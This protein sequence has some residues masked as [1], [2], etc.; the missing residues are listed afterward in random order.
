MSANHATRTQK[1]IQAEISDQDMRDTQGTRLLTSDDFNKIE[2]EAVA[3]K[4]K[5]EHAEKDLQGT[6][7][8]L[9][10]ALDKLWASKN[11]SDKQTKK[12]DVFEYSG[13]GALEENKRN[14]ILTE[15]IVELLDRMDRLG[16]EEAEEEPRDEK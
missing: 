12:R 15:E 7:A 9:E 10:K 14:W 13:S 8:Q 4:K 11:E 6:R 16:S 3:I 1:P 5:V 2:T